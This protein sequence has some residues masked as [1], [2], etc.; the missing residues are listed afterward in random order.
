MDPK[1]ILGLDFPECASKALVFIR[2][3][4]ARCGRPEL[5]TLAYKCILYHDFNQEQ[6]TWV[7]V[8]NLNLIQII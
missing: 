3:N 5:S 7:K 8:F 1:V 4:Y 2:N 6:N